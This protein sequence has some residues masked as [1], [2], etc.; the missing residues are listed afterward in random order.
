[1]DNNVVFRDFYIPPTEHHVY[2][3]AADVVLLPYLTSLGPSA[4]MMEAFQY[5][6]PV[7]ASDVD[8]LRNDISEGITGFLVPPG[9]C[10][11]L[12]NAINR[13]LGDDKLRRAME[14]N[15]ALVAGNYSIEEVSK[16]LK[17]IYL[18]L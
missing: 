12:A 10:D 2:Y 14:K 5:H 17:D 1:M 13:I 4:V 18:S 6:T 11:A 8:F 16:R 9:D 3:S 15:V 7:I